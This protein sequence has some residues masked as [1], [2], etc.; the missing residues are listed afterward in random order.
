MSKVVDAANK[1]TAEERKAMILNFIMAFLLLIPGVGEIADAA[2]MVT[3]RTIISL[4]GDT[5]NIALG[6]FGMVEDPKSAIFALFGFLSGGGGSGK[7]FIDAAGSRRGFSDKDKAT[8]APIK[9]DLDK[10]SN[11]RSLCIK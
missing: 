3:L 4:A 10:I 11:V 1:I 2:G 9:G 8:L 7:S 5:G 6:I